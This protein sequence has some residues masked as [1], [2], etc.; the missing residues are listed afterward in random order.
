[1]NT[2]IKILTLTLITLLLNIQTTKAQCNQEDWNALKTLY[3]STGGNNWKIQTGWDIHIAS[4][5]NP[6]TNCNLGDLYGVELDENGR[7]SCI[8]LDGAPNCDFASDGGNGL[9][10][11]IPPEIE[12]LSHLI[13]L[14]LSNNSLSGNLPS[15]FRL[16]LQTLITWKNC[17]YSIIY[18]LVV[19]HQNLAT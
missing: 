18:Y 2:T 9:T 6:P 1:M 13:H 17:F 12:N 10:G 16:N 14:N 5:N 4:Y 3:D 7:V 8:D 11:T 19:Y 15:T